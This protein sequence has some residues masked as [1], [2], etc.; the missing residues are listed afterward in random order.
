M[1]FILVKNIMAQLDY[2]GGIMKFT[3]NLLIYIIKDNYISKNKPIPSKDEVYKDF[4]D[5]ILDFAKRS[6]DADPSEKIFAIIVACAKMSEDVTL[7]DLIEEF[8]ESPDENK[9]ETIY[10]IYKFTCA[11]MAEYGKHL[12]L[13]EYDNI[14]NKVNMNNISS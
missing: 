2:M 13:R 6:D 12:F 5:A 7:D 3:E 4:A 9:A 10:K 14:I 8:K 11:S 1:I